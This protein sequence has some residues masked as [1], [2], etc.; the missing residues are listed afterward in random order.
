MTSKQITK[1]ILKS[2]E[3]ENFI[4]KRT[5]CKKQKP[6]VKIFEGENFNII[7]IPTEKNK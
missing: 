2:F 6:S 3:Y 4:E 5:N 1:I 7:I